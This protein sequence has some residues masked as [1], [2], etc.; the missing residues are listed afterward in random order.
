MNVLC[1]KL[2]IF[3]SEKRNNKPIKRNNHETGNININDGFDDRSK[4]RS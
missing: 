1:G 4:L 2:T 3:A